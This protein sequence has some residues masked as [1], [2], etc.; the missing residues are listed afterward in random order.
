MSPSR[1]SPPLAAARRNMAAEPDRG[2]DYRVLL[3]PPTR[4]DGEVSCAVL[5]RAGLSCTVCTEAAAL[6]AEIHS[7]VGAIVL[8]DAIGADADMMQVTAALA[9]Q[10]SW[11]DVPSILLSR[12][13]RQAVATSRLVAALTN[14]T[15]LDRPTSQRTLL[16]AVQA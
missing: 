11:S 13:D 1:L 8:T 3:L 7:G 9:R 2:H 10:P 16:S 6:A 15:I 14:V 5:E 4:R 12:T